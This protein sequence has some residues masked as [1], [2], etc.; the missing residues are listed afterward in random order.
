M[1]L[2]V[3]TLLNAFF[4]DSNKG[5]VLKRVIGVESAQFGLTI[6]KNKNN[7]LPFFI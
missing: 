6:T 5:T 1:L 3:V 2:Q 4:F 7:P